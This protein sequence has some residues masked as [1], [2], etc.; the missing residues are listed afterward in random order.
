ML[1]SQKENIIELIRNSYPVLSK[2]ATKR[3]KKIK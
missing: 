1:K 2:S 3:R